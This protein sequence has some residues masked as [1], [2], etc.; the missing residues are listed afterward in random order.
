MAMSRRP[1]A[2]FRHAVLVAGLGLLALVLLEDK[3]VA[4]DNTFSVIEK[5][6]ASFLRCSR[7]NG[8]KYWQS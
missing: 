1:A 8:K 5:V 2:H 6:K 4:A 3:V 7:A